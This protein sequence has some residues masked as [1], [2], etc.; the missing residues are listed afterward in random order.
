MTA[1]FIATT[2]KARKRHVCT[3]CSWPIEPGERYD[4]AATF[5]DRQVSVWKAH[6]TPCAAAADRAF[7]DGYGDG[8]LIDVDAVIAWA[9]EYEDEDREAEELARRVRVNAEV[10]RKLGSAS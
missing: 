9:E 6:M 7:F 8:G 4:R 3:V 2:P 10:A 5:H 1:T